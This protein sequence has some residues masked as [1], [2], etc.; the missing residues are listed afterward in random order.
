M[1]RDNSVELDSYINDL[2]DIQ[3]DDTTTGG[4]DDTVIE[5]GGD[6][7]NNGAN[8]NGLQQVQDD[9][10]QQQDQI[11]ASA[12]PVQKNGKQNEQ[13]QQQP[14]KNLRPAG[15]GAFFDEKGNLVDEKGQMIASGG[16]AAR[17]H[18]QNNRLKG[19]LDQRTE[20]LRQV[21]SQVGE[22]KALASAIQS[23]QLT[24]D[25]TARAL[26]YAGRMKRGDVLGVAKE[27]L[28]IIAAE[29]YNVTDL[30]GGDVGDTI[31]MRAVKNM[32]DDRLAP[33]TRQE[34]ARQQ[35]QQVHNNARRAYNEFIATNE[36]ADIHANEIALVA[37]Q[38]G[39]TPQQ[40][41]NH[42]YRYAVS[43]GLDFSQPLRPQ[44]EQLAA[45]R[46]NGGQQR[47]Q[48]QRQQ[49]PMP[50]GAATRNSGEVQT[51]AIQASADDDWATIIR[52]VQATMGQ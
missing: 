31:E 29:G 39:G 50:N 32:I 8:D 48:Q 42:L 28:A 26:D 47:Q 21:A 9:T 12:Q 40:A 38:F 10:Q 16:F 49:R 41:Y 30:L 35:D 17:M 6:D 20:E 36:F 1:G 14:K 45:A 44:M 18:Q 51:S 46:Q 7:T 13:Q 2:A 33:I 24:T 25:E 19:M 34:Q 15:P 37:K 43:N 4:G 5:N 23:Y 11:D 22:V 52:G 3:E 27:I